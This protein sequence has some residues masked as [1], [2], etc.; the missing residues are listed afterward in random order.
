MPRGFSIPYLRKPCLRKRKKVPPQVQFFKRLNGFYMAKPAHDEL[1]E[2]IYRALIFC[3][4]IPLPPF[5]QGQPK[6]LQ[7]DPRPI[8]PKPSP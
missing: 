8:S 6:N 7:W 5:S 3:Q 4:R 2:K 1:L